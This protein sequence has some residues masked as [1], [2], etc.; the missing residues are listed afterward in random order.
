MKR[1]ATFKTLTTLCLASAFF[2]ANCLAESKETPTLDLP[3]PVGHEAKGIKLPYF[4]EQGK[5]EMNFVIGRAK[6]LDEKRLQMAN[7]I[8]EMYDTD[9]APE[10]K[11]DLP[12]SVLNLDTHVITSK[13]P[14][15]IERSDFRIKGEGMRFN[16]E[17][18]QGELQG[19]VR[20]LIYD[21]QGANG[22]DDE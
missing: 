20:M 11:I 15:T 21:R 10:M 6:R 19:N 1:R 8:V 16:A 18:R 7:V 22:A 4:D 2:L 3:L 17:T 12:E 9:G 13:S 5:L 14:V